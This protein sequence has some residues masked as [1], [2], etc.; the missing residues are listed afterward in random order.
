MNSLLN[1]LIEETNDVLEPHL[2]EVKLEQ[3]QILQNSGETINQVYFPIDCLLSVTVTMQ[4]GDTAEVG[5][6]GNRGMLGVDA[7]LGNQATANTEHIVQIAGQAVTLGADL[8]RQ[9]FEQSPK[10]RNIL[11]GYA[12]VFLNQV[13]QTAACNRLHTLEQRFARWL[14]VAQSQVDS[15]YLELTQAFIAQM[16]G[17]RRA[18][19]TQAAQKLQLNGA[20]RYHHGRIQILNQAELQQSAC[21]CYQVMVQQYDRSL[22]IKM[23]QPKD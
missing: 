21:E 10:V 9:V 15:S 7:L 16:L 18:G 20:I 6:V 3:S 12:Q 4:N 17:V 22:G 14:L 5:T 13:S 19:V 11:L 8:L 2:R 23:S 1:W